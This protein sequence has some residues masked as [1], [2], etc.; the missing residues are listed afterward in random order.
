MSMIF[1]ESNLSQIFVHLFIKPMFVSAVFEPC[2][3]SV[4]SFETPLITQAV[5]C[6]T[7][8]AKLRGEHI[9]FWE[10]GEG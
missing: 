9:F 3:K 1:K 10:G 4:Q 7:N 8:H 6:K 2:S 5:L